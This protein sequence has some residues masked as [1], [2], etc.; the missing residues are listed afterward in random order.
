MSCSA[1]RWHVV[2]ALIVF[3]TLL[4]APNWSWSAEGK[5]KKIVLIAGPITGHPKHT[6]EYEKNVILLKHL[7]DTAPNLKGVTVE[8]HFNGW[9][10]DPSTLDDADTIVMTS[11]GG[12][13]NEASHP[14]Y[15]E[16]RMQVIERQMKRGC[17]FMQFHWST[18]NPSRF[19]DQITE[20]VGG[21]F[22]YETGDGP[23]KW[24][25]AIKTWEGPAK[26]PTPDHPICRGVK[27]FRVK[28]EFYYRIRFREDDSRTKPIVTTQPPG[29]AQDYAV[30]WA[31]ERKNGGRGFGFTGGHF[32]D[33]WWNEDFRKL[34]LNAV[35]WTAGAEV[36]AEGVQSTLA[37]PVKALV[38]TGHN[39]PAHDWRKVT[40]ALIQV[41]E[42]DPRVFVDVTENIEDLATDKID[43]YDLLVMNYSS[44]DRA[45]LSQKGKDNF[46]R[47]LKEG[48]GGLSVIHFANGSFTD[49]L[50]NKEAD[51]E[52]FR[53]KIVRRVWVHGEGR[54]GHDA[55][56]P[57]RVDITD[58][59]HP[60]TKGMQP[61]QTVDELYYRQEGPLPIEPLATAMS[62]NTGKAAPMAFAY[63]YGKAR[64]FQTVL[65]HSDQ[66]VRLAGAL[67]RRG[68]VW[69][70]GKEN[71]TFDPPVEITVDGLFRGGSQ[72]TPAESA[73]R[74]APE[75]GKQSSVKPS[76]INP[77][78]DG[79]FGKALD[80]RAGGA[81]VSGRAPFRKPPLTVECWAKLDNKAG[82]NILV[83]NELKSSA[84][85]WELYSYTRTGALSFY[86]PGM[87]PVEIKSNV[88]ICD[89][90]WH[91]LAATY[92]PR[93]VK[94]FV[95][96]KLVKEQ[97]I[98]SAG[99]ATVEGDL[100]I[101]S[102]VSRGIGFAGIIDE[103]RISNT[104]REISSTP[105]QPFAKDDQTIGLW[106]F[107][108]LNDKKQFADESSQGTP[109]VL[110]TAA[111]NQ[112][113][114]DHWGKDAVGFRSTE[115][116]WSDGRWNR[117]DVGRFLAASIATPKEPTLKGLS[118]RLGDRGQAAVCFDT[119]NLVTRAGWT[120]DFLRFDPTRFGLIRHPVMGGI[121]RHST[122][123][124]P[125][126]RLAYKGHYQH[127][128]RVVLAYEIDGAEVLQSPWVVEQD[129]LTVFTHEFQFG[130]APP[131]LAIP[132]CDTYEGTCRD[133]HKDGVHFVR[134]EHA[135]K[136][137]AVA[138]VGSAAAL[139]VDAGT[140]WLKI[141]EGTRSE[142][143][144]VLIWSGAKEQVQRFEAIATSK[145]RSS[146]L[147]KLTE[148]GPT[149]W[150]HRLATGGS[151]GQGDGPFVIDTINIP[152][153]NPY[154]A[155]MFLG[156]HDF[157]SNGDAAVCTVHG[158]VW[159]VRGIGAR[160]D[161]V[162]WK[163]FATGLFQPLGLK[164]IADQIY[165]LGRD[166]ITR[167]HDRDSNDEADFYE[168]FNNDGA[169]SF[170]NHDYATC[171][172]TDSH[173]DFF[174]LRGN[175]GL[176]RVSRDGR[177]HELFATGFRNPHGMSIGPD[178]TITVAPQ[179]GEWTPGSCIAQVQ[180]GGHYG[181][182]GPRK[183][184]DRPL[185]YD[186]PLCWIPRLVDNSSGGQVWVPK[187]HWGP[188][189]GSL[190][191]LSFGRC[192]M[193][194]ALREEIDGQPQGGLVNMGLEFESGASRARFNPVDGH[195]YV[196]GL[197]GWVS[198]AVRDG[199]LQ[200][201]RYTGAKIDLPTGLNVHGN[202]IVI[203]FAQPLDMKSAQDPDNYFIQQWN[204]R[205]S[206]EYG[207]PEYKVS[208]P[209][210]LGRDEVEVKSAT[211]LDGGRSV[212]LEIANLKPVMQMQID[213]SLRA[214]DG[215]EVKNSIYNTI[216][217]VPATKIK[218]GTHARRPRPGELAADLRDRLRPG[219]IARFTQGE[220]KDARTARMAALFVPQGSHPTPWLDAAP[221]S[222]TLE[223]FLKVNLPGKYRF[224]IQGTG[225][226][227]LA[228]N[229]Q[230]IA[231]SATVALHRGFNQIKISFSSPRDAEAQLRLFWSSDAFAAEPLPPRILFHD[232][233][234]PQL[235]EAADRR[236]GRELFATLHCHR[237]HQTD[238][239][240]Q[241]G[242]FAFH[243]LNRQPPVLDLAGM[244]F[245][246]GWLYQWMLDPAALQNH[247]SMPSLLD[248]DRKGDRQRALHMTAYLSSLGSDAASS[249]DPVS[250]AAYR[251]GEVLFETLGCISC[252]RLT[253]PTEDDEFGRRSLHFVSAKFRPGMLKSFLVNPHQHHAWSRMP[254]FRL[255]DAEGEALAAYLRSEAKGR[256]PAIN[257]ADG[258][259]VQGRKLFGE[260]QCINCHGVTSNQT[261]VT[262]QGAVRGADGCLGADH[263]SRRSPDFRLHDE[264]RRAITS[265]L[266]GTDHSLSR[267]S[268]VEAS[269]RLVRRLNCAACHERDGQP[270]Q[271]PEILFEEGTQGK[272][273][274]LLPHLT[275]AGEKLNP[276]W[277]EKM[278]AGKIKTPPRAW[279]TSRMPSFPSD[280]HVLATGLAAQHGFSNRPDPPR[281]INDELGE[282]GRR[283]SLQNGG[284]DCR[285]CH[286][287]GSRPPDGDQKSNI[288]L[289]T[290]L[291]IMAD[292]LRKEY[293]IRWMNDPLRVDPQT[294]MP[295]YA[296]GG[297]TKVQTILDGDASR[298]FEALWHYIQ[299][300]SEAG[301]N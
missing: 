249:F 59:A 55:F 243:E 208:N 288:A 41:I 47:Y 202:G 251:E 60:I 207:S 272:V 125:R 295:K 133:S 97:A 216:N 109:A 135:D 120:G 61:F 285:Q 91:Y 192:W 28:E 4:V 164:I 117:S 232:H 49:T 220:T 34:I 143:C 85:H 37:A 124:K 9:P 263:E 255:T 237:C 119:K 160:L 301:D 42:Q 75:G 268:N 233:G 122:T 155:L 23:R 65:G 46:T 92:E 161:K 262:M 150:P 102:L 226:T 171:L 44:W 76:N 3:S 36:P 5:T 282:A 80:G 257:L 53:T 101:G 215:I 185:G 106:H 11:D 298:Q 266:S 81:I 148:P 283:L 94:L 221:F 86:M 291:S 72:W 50:P 229:G 279:L 198:S 144:Q 20:W 252:H 12:D 25:S 235:M 254:N 7:L 84:T 98:E 175:T 48:R 238:A 139:V 134:V 253:P 8:A 259:P 300:V 172:E 26:L 151:L 222:A 293:Y 206:Q 140:V 209:A 129:G 90:K 147:N 281:S 210:Q 178:D 258:D 71:I 214:A 182:Q 265:F 156:G 74:A 87:R 35:V 152:F 286:G 6:H 294:K 174:Y 260:L 145:Q 99:G 289:G 89:G 234:D 21:Y 115:E 19:H 131:G 186:R 1:L 280:A 203:R 197:K 276:R 223:G 113:P 196:S 200:R 141:P 166:Q 111:A 227:V 128:Q 278:I 180:Q 176:E 194:L 70:A 27:P 83:A 218:P 195:L 163:R 43:D 204:Y 270:T 224:R 177:R 269:Q 52:E 118:I 239:A 154:R 158:D 82:F 187:D 13:R 193:L 33:N 114:G 167:L 165:A 225:T 40:A 2:T 274:E 105:E 190:L 271:W 179:E 58:V 241:D 78:A 230:A 231:L 149:I 275:W 132:I 110:S 104:V 24:Y 240:K 236:G 211:L 16:G 284:L 29:E 18:F 217:I 169:T 273:P 250:D 142:R 45:G 56:G 261:K 15:V 299:S 264:Q 189:S 146:D 290:N 67:I 246:P 17:G 22:D 95:D 73:K 287:L 100:A 157:F 267:S 248:P 173:G 54:S 38:L 63:K 256:T 183:T 130:R 126:G 31:V 159:L 296:S 153:E 162:T 170:G 277:M 108:R 68:T 188:L 103:V 121:V 30:G 57:F 242:R 14:L 77:I 66:S 116:D 201:V 213:Y 212:F 168:N 191:S 64:V 62:K 136:M 88:D 244:R 245:R 199:C 32:Y 137:T 228:I 219:L 138:A 127:G 205:Y 39:H 184:P 93:Q 51:W 297:R 292:R 247:A 10:D 79:R 181:Y 96:G 69:A 123:Q 112:S 107:D